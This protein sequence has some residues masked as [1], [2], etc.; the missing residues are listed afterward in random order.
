MKTHNTRI[1]EEHIIKYLEKNLKDCPEKRFTINK[2]RESF[3][4]F[5]YDRDFEEWVTLP[6]NNYVIC[7]ECKREVQTYWHKHTA[8]MYIQGEP[9]LMISPNKTE[10]ILC[11]HC[12]KEMMDNIYGRYDQ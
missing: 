7:D 2:L 6:E 5:S 3:E 10:T 1:K 12:H 4:D 11:K 9:R 8:Y